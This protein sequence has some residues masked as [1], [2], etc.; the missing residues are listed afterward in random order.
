MIFSLLFNCIYSVY[1]VYTGVI[2][3]GTR[4]VSIEKIRKDWLPAK[5]R[6]KN[7]SAMAGKSDLHLYIYDNKP[8]PG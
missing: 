4:Q 6:D 8:E 2:A 7:P 5:H 1:D 3:A